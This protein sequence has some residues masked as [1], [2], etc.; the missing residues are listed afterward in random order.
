MKTTKNIESVSE[1]GKTTVVNVLKDDYDVYIGRANAGISKKASPFANPF[2]V[3]L[4]G[5]DGAIKKFV[6]WFF[7][8]IENDLEFRAQVAELDGK[9]LGCWCKPD[10]CHG[11]VIVAYLEGEPIKEEWARPAPSDTCIVCG[12]Q[13]IGE[14]CNGYCESS[15]QELMEAMSEI[16]PDPSVYIEQYAMAYRSDASC[17]FNHMDAEI[18]LDENFFK[19]LSTAGV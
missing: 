7:D 6:A 16:S 9:R 17:F 2:S 11:D 8:K 4:Y 5:R 14:F 10:V 15:Y 19:P 12:D 18:W 1:I 3:K 13:S